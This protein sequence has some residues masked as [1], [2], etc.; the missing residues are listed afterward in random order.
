MTRLLQT[1]LGPE[2]THT[3]KITGIKTYKFSIPTGQHVHDSKTGE[4]ISS[5]SKAWLFLKIET[6]AGIDGWGEGS[7]E[8]LTP[9]VEATLHEWSTLLI[10][11]ASK[12]R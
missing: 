5:N 1:N 9:P 12:S 3:M 4:L 2:G 8:W 6:D 7:G 11:C 10:F